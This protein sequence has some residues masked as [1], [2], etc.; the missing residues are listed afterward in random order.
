MSPSILTMSEPEDSFNAVPRKD[1]S[2][3]ADLSSRGGSGLSARERF[4]N[5]ACACETSSGARASFALRD[6][7][8][9]EV[10]RVVAERLSYPDFHTPI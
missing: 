9:L 3:T 6:T 1:F 7:F 2:R 10:I 8:V 5:N 4:V